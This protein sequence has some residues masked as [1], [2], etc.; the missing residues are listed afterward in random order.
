MR[1]TALSDFYVEYR[2][3]A[4]APIEDAAKRVEMLSELHANIQDVF[5]QHGVQIMSPHYM[6]E[7]T[8]PQVVPKARWWMAPAKV[9]GAADRGEFNG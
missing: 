5:N 2:L 8:A 4:Y 9:P 6:T 3:L 7:P 1:R